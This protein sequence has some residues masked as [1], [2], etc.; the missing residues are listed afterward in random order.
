[1]LL[2]VDTLEDVDTLTLLQPFLLCIRSPTTSGFIT[3]LT[4]SSVYKLI[5]YSI[6]NCDSKNVNA[7]LPPLVSALTHCRFEAADQASDDTVLLRV[8]KLLELLM[9]SSLSELLSD[10]VVI[11]VLQTCLVLACNKRRSEVLR[12]ASEMTV[13]SITIRVFSKLQFII[14]E[15]LNTGIPIH[16]VDY[17]HSKFPTGH[18]S[19]ETSPKDDA[20]DELTTTGMDSDGSNDDESSRP[21]ITSRRERALSTA[22]R[23]SE[24]VE[25]NEQAF[26]LTCM[27]EFLS[28]LIAMISPSNQLNQLESNRNFCLTLINVSLEVSGSYFTKHA[29]L[30]SLASDDLWKNVTQILQ[31]S[32]SQVLLISAVRLFASLVTSLGVESAT[33]YQVELAINTIL[34]S[35]YDGNIDDFEKAPLPERTNSLR[36]RSSTPNL[37]GKSTPV[38]TSRPQSSK[39]ILIDGLVSLWTKQPTFFTNLFKIYDCDFE[40]SDVATKTIRFL[41]DCAMPSSPNWTSDVLPP[42]CLDGIFSFLISISNRVDLMKVSGIQPSQSSSKYLLN[43]EKKYSFI[44]CANKFNESAKAGIKLLEKRGFISSSEDPVIVADFLFKR[45][46]RLNKKVLGEYLAKPANITILFEFMKLF[47]FK[48]LRLDEAL[49][50]LLRS[51]RLPGESQQIERI[52]ETF[53]ERY[54][55]C[56]Q[57]EEKTSEEEKPEEK[58]ESISSAGE[59][60]DN[61]TKEERLEAGDCV[62]DKDAGFILSYSII[63]LNTDLH[64]PQVKKPMSIS[65]YMNNLRATNGGKDFPVWYLEKIYYSIQE[66]EIVMP[67]EHHKSGMWSDELWNN[68]VSKSQQASLENHDNGIDVLESNDLEQLAIFDKALFEESWERVV[69]TL[70]S[71]FDEASDDNIV[72]KII[73]AL[74]KCASIAAFYDIPKVIEKIVTLL[75]SITSLKDREAIAA[76]DNNSSQEALPTTQLEVLDQNKRCTI[77]VSD[78]AVSF[79]MDIRAQFATIVTF[80]ITALNE[81]YI[82][83]IGWKDISPIVLT[84]LENNLLDPNIFPETQ[85]FLN[86]GPLPSVKPQYVLKT[87]TGKENGI[88]SALS[89]FM[90]GYSDEPPEPSEDEIEATLCTIDC[91]KS[92]SLLEIFVNARKLK[93][94]VLGSFIDSFVSLLPDLEDIEKRTFIPAT[95]FIL[96]MLVSLCLNTPLE[97][98]L[99]DLVICTLEKYIEIPVSKGWDYEIK[100]RVLIY[101]FT[102]LRIGPSSP[103]H[104]KS[105]LNLIGKLSS[106]ERSSLQNFSTHLINPL[107]SLVDEGAWSCRTVLSSQEY[108]VIIRA[109]AANKDTTS[110]VFEFVEGIIKSSTK[111]INRTNY[112]FLLGVL[113]EIAAIGAAGAQFEQLNDHIA[114]LGSNTA[115]KNR[116]S[117]FKD[118]VERAI[119][120]IDLTVALSSLTPAIA[121]RERSRKE[122]LTSAEEK[123]EIDLW[124][125]MIQALAHQCLNP[126]REIRAHALSSCQLA[127]LSW[128]SL[129]P[130]ASITLSHIFDYGLFP[131]ILELLKSEVFE[132]DPYGMDKTRMEVGSLICKVFLFYVNDATK[133]HDLAEL[134]KKIVDVLYQLVGLSKDAVMR[135]SI[136]ESLKNALLVLSASVGFS[137]SDELWT[138]TESSLCKMIPGIRETLFPEHPMITSKISE[139]TKEQ[140]NEPEPVKAEVVETAKPEQPEILDGQVEPEL[141]IKEAEIIETE[142]PA[143]DSNNAS[144]SV[145]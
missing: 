127:I 141:K 18:E 10:E 42:Q 135:E 78:V 17:P 105:L 37:S 112:I 25:S 15:E 131:L 85:S 89:S 26:G 115:A 20:P 86:L 123:L 47:N 100:S 72:M 110:D 68:V 101:Y 121:E 76:S 23:Q 13:T 132:T 12:K 137:E 133:E 83:K 84:L 1:M 43:K 28:S 45:S 14:P 118:D 5:T 69:F 19:S 80:R 41:C 67:E 142:T 130:Y 75:S 102:V 4:I 22:T 103:E 59:V 51:F 30:I 125:S 39:E 88:L 48:G 87:K 24:A 111:E 104:E 16:M 58:P 6:I 66:R 35:L 62:A 32:D 96:E 53:A 61:E 56:Q 107:A 70:A 63:L 46:G 91:I 140:R 52:V 90:K 93:Q 113:D 143:D 40:S 31:T 29:K 65:E 94:P 117:P 139:E 92:S 109:F 54:I 81:Q 124:L 77:T 44:N 129:I 27:A 64:N 128:K 138:T 97:S 134:W 36:K 33:K 34:Q 120:S 74:D 98:G 116:I 50:I 108:W 145:S 122:V 114:T 21:E 126:C 2:E 60:A 49:R 95:L 106:I 9:L 73:G 71:I 119:K 136:V 55:E 99:R 3:A 8:L 144:D 57:R 38:N 79:G 82:S 7:A 11:E